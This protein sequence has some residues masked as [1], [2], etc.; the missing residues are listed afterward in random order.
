MS[1]TININACDNELFLIAYPTT[2]DK[3]FTLAHIKSGNGYSVNVTIN[4]EEGA[5]SEV[6]QIN[7]VSGAIENTYTAYLPEGTYTIVASC[8]NWG[9]P[10]AYSYN[11]NNGNYYKSSGS[12]GAGSITNGPGMTISAVP[13]GETVLTFSKIVD[14]V[15]TYTESG[16][17]LSANY[18][19]GVT[20]GNLTPP[21]KAVFV[22]TLADLNSLL[23][24][25]LANGGSFNLV[26]LDVSGMG[27]AERDS[28]IT[29]V[30]ANGET[31]THTIRTEQS[32]DFVT[33]KMPS[34]FVNLTSVKLGSQLVVTTNVKLTRSNDSTMK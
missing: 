9:G 4:V 20:T 28:I 13:P 15:K 27:L 21:G 23:T 10:W 8:I 32:V 33:Y 14:G 11:L 5:H 12:S 22:G 18:R 31:V 1:N 17:L 24:L 19:I 16:Y 6:E 7:G 2:S 29:G 30:L 34:S 25:K 26:S 3:S